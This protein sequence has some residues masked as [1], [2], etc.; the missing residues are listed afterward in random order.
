MIDVSVV[1]PTFNRAGTLCRAVQSCLGQP[2]VVEAIVVDDGS[3][4]GPADAVRSMFGAVLQQE[5]TCTGQ[6]SRRP[7]GPT[8]D[9]ENPDASVVRYLAQPNQGVCAARN[10]G[11]LAARGEFVKFLDSD[12]ELLPGA[13]AVELRAARESGADAVVSAWEERVWDGSQERAELRQ[14]IRCRGLA[15]GI[16]DMLLGAAP[17]TAAALYRRA[18]VSP[19]RWNPDF[20]KADDWGWAWTVGLAGARFAMVDCVSAVYWHHGGERITSA[21]TAFH[22]ST[23]VRQRIL[24]MVEQRLHDTGGLS[25]ERAEALSQYYYKDRL[26]VCEE[27]PAEWRELW[28]HCQV[29]A[30]GFRP[31]EWDRLLRP[32]VAVC[33]P[34]WGVRAYVGLRVLA[35]QAGLR[36][37]KV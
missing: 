37:V 1:I 13:L 19:L 20:G 6:A 12:D 28:H 25:R 3:T 21:P 16:D 23:V 32:F 24:R 36:R 30:P 9:E 10:R 5:A 29:L 31:A 22:D 33:G 27:S 8:T 34:Y 14:V 2:C 26:V 15:R 11:L 18:F 35:R 4:D 17:W 7:C